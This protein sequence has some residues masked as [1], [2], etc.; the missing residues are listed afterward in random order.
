L[1][2]VKISTTDMSGQIQRKEIDLLDVSYTLLSIDKQNF[3]NTLREVATA[4]NV[5][6]ETEGQAIP[7]VPP[8]DF[9]NMKQEDKLFLYGP[10]GCGKS[11]IIFE[12]IKEKI[13]TAGNICIINPQNTI[14]YKSGRL[15]LFELAGGFNREDVILWDGFPDDL[16]TR[17][18]DTARRVL[19]VITSKNIKYLIIALKPKYL[20]IYRNLSDKI[21]ELYIHEV[22]FDREKIKSVIKSYGTNIEQ[23]THVYREYLSGELDNISRRLWQKEPIPST[24]LDYL[25]ELS[26]KEKKNSSSSLQGPR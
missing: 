21:V 22:A 15:N 13:K 18:V 16:V 7:F 25:K 3:F 9:D 12:I 5:Q 6:L 24:V 14:G 8:L 2:G 11:R 1:V 20:E 4:I 26:S 17:D 23:F 10:S 19:E